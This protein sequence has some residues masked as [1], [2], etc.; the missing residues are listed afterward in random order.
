MPFLSSRLSG[1]AR[2][3]LLLLI[4]V[5]ILMAGS[6][7]AQRVDS[8]DAASNQDIVRIGRRGGDQLGD[9]V[10]TGDF[11]GDGKI[12]FA[13]GAPGYSGTANDRNGSGAIFVFYGNAPYDR[14]SDLGSTGSASLVVLGPATGDGIGSAFTFAD[15]NNDGT[16]DLIIGN[17]G[18][19]GPR[20]VDADGDGTI[21]A[22]GLPGRG[23]VY[24]LFGG[25]VRTSPFDLSRPDRSKSRADLWIIG[26]EAGDQLGAAV[27]VADIDGD[28]SAD[29]ILGATGADGPSNARSD[30]GEIAVLKSTVGPFVDGTRNFR[31]VAPDAIITG[32]AYDFQKNDYVDFNGD[33][34][35]DDLDQDGSNCNSPGGDPGDKRVQNGTDGIFNQFDGEKGAIGDRLAVGDINNDGRADIAIRLPKGRGT[36]AQN[37]DSAGEVAIVLGQIGFSSTDLDLGIPIRITGAF[38]GDDAGA[39]IAISDVDGDGTRDLIVGSPFYGTD[40]QDGTVETSDRFGNGAVA[41]VWG[42]LF[43]GTTDLRSDC[44]Y[45]CGSVLDSAEVWTVLG[46]DA[47]DGLGNSVAVAD[48]DGDG[49]VELITGAPFADGPEP[50]QTRASSGELW[51]RWG[52]GT[53]PLPPNSTVDFLIDGTTGWGRVFGAAAGDGFGNTVATGNLDSDPKKEIVLGAPF[54]DGPNLGSGD[55]IGAGKGYLISSVDDDFDSFRNLFDNCPQIPNS[56]NLD[57]DNDLFG[58][59]CDNCS[60]LSNR[61][62]IDSDLDTAGDACD[63]D[64]DNDGLND[65]DGDASNDPCPTGVTFG[66]DDNCRTVANNLG[67]PSPQ[68]DTD[69]DGIGNKCDNCP[70]NANGNQADNDKDGTGDLCDSDDDNDGFAD[71][72]DKCPLTPGA[73][74]DA[75]GDG[76]GDICDNCPST[77]NASQTDQDGDGA[78]DACDNCQSIA[79]SDQDDQDGD[80]KGGACDNCPDTSNADQADSDGDNVGNVCDNCSTVANPDQADTDVWVQ[81]EGPG[82]YNECVWGDTD[83]DTTIDLDKE[84]FKD[85]DKDNVKDANETEII[86]FGHDKIGDACDNCARDCNPFQGE[87]RSPIPSFNDSDKVGAYC[88]NCGTK[89]NGDCNVN[90]LYCDLNNDGTTTTL[91]RSQGFQKNT[92]GDP[93]G[94][95]CDP[96][97]DN[98]LIPD[99]VANKPACSGGATTQCDDNCRTVVNADQ[100]DTDSDAVGNVC[101]NCR[102]NPNTSQLDTDLDGLGD[103]CDNCPTVANPDQ[104][105]AD[106]DGSGNPCDPDD[107]ND[108]KLDS[109]GDGTFDPCTGGNT[110]NCDDNCPFAANASQADADSDGIGDV[111]DISDIDLR[112]DDQSYEL[113]GRDLL[114]NLGRTAVVGD[115]NGDGKPDLIVGAPLGDAEFNGTANRDSEAGEVHIIFGKFKNAKKDLKFTNSDVVIYGERAS[116]EFGRSLAV[117]DVN[118]D[119]TVDLIVGALRGDCSQGKQDLDGDGSVDDPV[120]G[121]GRVYM[122]AGRTTWPTKILTYQTATP[123][124]PNATATVIGQ[125]NGTNLGRHLAIGDVNADG[126]K[127][128]VIGAPNFSL[129]GTGTRRIIYGAVVVK[130]GQAGWTG[131][132]DYY[133]ATPD[134]LIRGAEEVDRLGTVVGA[135]DINGDGTA[136]ILC[137][138]RAADGPGNTKDGAGELALVFGGSTIIAGGSRDLAASPAPY[139]YGVDASDGL[140]AGLAVGDLNGDGT[141]DMLIGVTGGRGPGNTRGTGVGEAYAVFGRTTWA[142]SQ[143]NT[144]ANTLIYGRRA[145]D[146]FGEQTAIGE[147]DGDGTKDIVITATFSAGAANTRANAGDAS[148]FRWNDIKNSATVDLLNGTGGK[149]VTALLSSDSGDDLGIGLTLGDM[150]QDGVDELIIGA[151][152]GDGD[153]DATQNRTDT[154]ELWIVAPTD[155]DGDGT[156]LRNL[157]DN[158][159][160]ISNA[161]Q[162][163]TDLDGVG[164]ACDNCPLI[165]NPDQVDTDLDGTGDLCEQDQDSDTVSDDD[166]DGTVDKCTGGNRVACDDNCLGLANPTQSD[167]DADGTGD[168]CDSDDDGDAVADASDNCPTVS[169]GSQQD[170]DGDGVG[171]ACQTLVRDLAGTGLAIYG[172]DAG[173]ATAYSGAIGDFNGDGTKDLLLGA[174]YADGPTNNRVDAGAAY[175]WFGPINQSEDL[176]T[177]RADVEIYGAAAGDRTGYAVAAG[178]LNNDGRDDIIIGAPYGDRSGK[179]DPGKVY[180]VFGAVSLPATKDLNSSAANILFQG[181]NN[182]DRLGM[183]LQV[184]DCNGNGKKDLAMGAPYSAADFDSVAGGGEIWIVHQENMGTGLII[185]SFTPNVQH[186]IS[187]AGADDHASASMAAADVSGDGTDDLIIGAPDADGSANNESQA[188]EVYVVKGGASMATTINLRIASN[189]TALF[190]GESTGDRAG[191]SLATGRFDAD[192][193]NDIA[194]GTPGQ[195]APPGAGARNAAGGGYVVLGRS[196]FTSINGKVFP[197]PA[198]V[199]IFGSTTDESMGQSIALGDYDNDGTNDLLF[200]APSVDAVSGTRTD[201]GAVY[202]LPSSRIPSGAVVF[203]GALIPSAQQIVGRTTLDQLGGG[204]I[205]GDTLGGPYW[206]AVTDFD[207]STNKE[208]VAPSVFGD[209]S[210]DTRA[211]AGEAWVV[212]Q[213][214]QDRD[215]QVDSTDCFPTDPTKARPRDTGTTSRFTT[216]TIFDWSDVGGAGITYNFY[217]GTVVTPWVYNETCLVKNLATSQGT[218]ATLPGA[219]QAF[220]YESTASNGASCVGPLGKNSQQVDR[221]TAPA[222]P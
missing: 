92:D 151:D 204:K 160:R 96:D 218:D 90:P 34:T 182:N 124:I 187:G 205:A 71:A 2:R 33:G 19:N 157:K 216:K 125:W 102:S 200:G 99:D 190:F 134:Y 132:T 77:S 122:F 156:A 68:Q 164:N 105:D 54:A 101:D 170:A 108:G 186:Y 119:G 28:N 192:S 25:R 167:I 215:G 153:N 35:C 169:N 166:G 147:F 129:P 24:V 185:D 197:D 53:R 91:E 26:A 136:D 22:N 123:N 133:T 93:T 175:V 16:S 202:V 191:S 127:D 42:P 139:L 78:G 104:I 150:N 203:D 11:N 23:E 210:S 69:L 65:T 195:G 219:G 209:G 148:V 162:T 45:K 88:D 178:D 140:P 212:N 137:G 50:A 154:G 207:G 40:D 9:L 12:D 138:A 179:T 74:G 84:I 131:A 67:D 60:S 98:D 222:C 97:D 177:T 80:G 1:A 198:K 121:C 201:A 76:K 208:V 39:A 43:S 7:E 8:V 21:D 86:P 13:L 51:I 176:F 135:G 6:A 55:R 113:Y 199:S 48:H 116:D 146:N 89:N 4:A 130:F 220:W 110:V 44:R 194:I 173:D 31:T 83:G 15:L 59:A 145:S 206:L 52:T 165:A 64:D 49:T 107:D 152:A 66:C 213:A 79:N 181:E 94:D 61:D 18:G 58:D 47:D 41:V 168:A 184:L 174:P 196:D 10:A 85:L 111:C 143:V 126:I 221:P 46:R 128:I 171:N 159:P 82:T 62:Q 63:T 188:G 30:C 29:L 214:D 73:N 75:D 217:R 72:I 106:V 3:G 95:A 120:D 5:P 142:T 155:A 32:P 141:A 189:Y 37:R 193:I 36:P 172:Q 27:A 57:S 103:A 115:I 183:T 100:A 114:D 163:D 211:D 70:T 81:E 109:D 161:S 112:T 14:T 144:V 149:P 17:P 180:V 117:G 87:G 118:A 158:C 38:P 56:P 20:N